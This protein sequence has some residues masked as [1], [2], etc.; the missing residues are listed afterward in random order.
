[1]CLTWGTPTASDLM[2]IQ[3]RLLAHLS[4]AAQVRARLCPMNEWVGD[5]WLDS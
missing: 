3:E 2:L 5:T 1:M 4:L